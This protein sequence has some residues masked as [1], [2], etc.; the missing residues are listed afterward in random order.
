MIISQHKK[1]ITVLMPTHNGER[2][3]RTAIDSVLA[4]TFS[5][6]ELLI[7][8]DGSTDSTP[9]IIR[10]YNDDRIRVIDNECNIGITKSLNKGLKKARGEYIARLDDDDMALPERLEKQRKFLNKNKDI[11]LVGSW[12]EYIDQN[13]KFMRM[14]K[15]PTDSRV[16]RYEL[17]FGNN[18]YHSALMFRKSAILDIGGYDESFKHAQDY[19]LL[20]RLRDTHKLANIPEALIRYRINPKSIVSSSESQKVVHANAIAIIKKMISRYKRMS[21]EEYEI[22]LNAFII[23]KPSRILT[24][25]EIVRAH[26]LHKELFHSYLRI[27]SEDKSVLLPYYARRKKLMFKKHAIIKVKSLGKTV[28]GN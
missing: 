28:K 12:A 24:V 7:I 26:S 18:F 17:I 11:A 4:Q 9:D 13:G 16:I 21:D 20:S 10:S 27:H 19:E 5:D 6:F 8:N 1:M 15:T 14:R 2:Y 23:K 3:I 25:K 22:F